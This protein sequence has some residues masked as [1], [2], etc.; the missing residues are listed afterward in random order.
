MM[1]GGCDGVADALDILR[2]LKREQ[3]G[4]E[5]HGFFAPLP[6]ALHFLGEP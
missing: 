5:C 4:G 1:D 3:Q 6:I 2:V